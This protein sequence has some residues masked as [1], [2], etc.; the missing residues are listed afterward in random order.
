MNAL[1]RGSSAIRRLS[2][3]KRRCTVLSVHVVVNMQQNPTQ[4][5]QSG[6]EPGGSLLIPMREERTCRDVVMSLTTS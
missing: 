1:R 3:K 6:K 5:M 4:S 2:A